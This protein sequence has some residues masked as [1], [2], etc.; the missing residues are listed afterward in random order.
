MRDRK[1]ALLAGMGQTKPGD[2]ILCGAYRKYAP[3][4]SVA[5]GAVSEPPAAAAGFSGR[6]S[7]LRYAPPVRP[8]DLYELRW[9]SDPRVSPDG[10][11]VAFVS[12]SINRETN[13]YRA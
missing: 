9:A 4:T 5:T 7:G 10:L 8:E 12:R 13:E 3:Q 11:T 1:S 6:G 2:A